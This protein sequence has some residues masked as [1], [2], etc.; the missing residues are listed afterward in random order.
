MSL[1]TI[2]KYERLDVIGHGASG[3][4]YLAKDTLLGR[5]VAL[6]VISA[7]GEE[8]DRV[9]EEARVLDRLS[10]PNILEVHGVDLID[11]KV[12]IDME[13]VRGRDLQHIL[14]QTPQLPIANA[15]SITAQICDG[16]A[17]AHS[18][19]TVHR[20]VKP[21]NI[22]ISQEGVVKLV[23]FGLAEVLGTNSFAVGAGTYSYMAPEDFNE[24]Q[25]SDK[26]SDIWAVGVMLYEMLAGKRPFRASKV[27]DPFSW[28]RAIE[29][30]PIE[31]LRT[32]RPE[33]PESIEK[34]IMKAL[35]R[36]KGARYQTADL[37]ATDIRATGLVS[38]IDSSILIVDKAGETDTLPSDEPS[39]ISNDLPTVSGNGIAH[40]EEAATIA[41]ITFPKTKEKIPD[42]N[43]LPQ[44]T[45]IDS[46]LNLAPDHWEPACDAF[47]GGTLVQWLAA[48]GETPLAAVA[49]EIAN[50][51]SRDKNE[52]LRDF[53]YRAGMETSD[54]AQKR[55]NRGVRYFDSGKF[56]EASIELRSAAR[57]DPMRPHY[58]QYLA[59]SLKAIGDRSAAVA[60]FQDGLSY[61]PNDR[62]LKREY[63]EMVDSSVQISSE[64]VDFGTLRSGETKSVRINIK[65]AGQGAL[66]GRVTS[67]PEWITVEPSTFTTRQRQPLNIV[68]DASKVWKAPGTYK[69]NIV[70]E[71]TGGR[72][73][74]NVSLSVMPSRIGLSKAWFWY[75][76]LFISC[77]AP[78]FASL[79]RGSF[80]AGLIATSLLCGSF[81]IIALTAD[82]KW[83]L[84]WPM[85]VLTPFCIALS[86]ALSNTSMFHNT[87]TEHAIT[88]VVPLIIVMLIVQALALA[89]NP[90]G[91]GRWPVW[92]CITGI[93]GFLSAYALL[94][95]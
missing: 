1:G 85:L 33:I 44:L 5:Q 68:A 58:H 94:T 9:L 79:L 13:Y 49:E 63:S 78:A 31:P 17:Y 7:Q 38:A 57:L 93:A 87:A 11:G 8:R 10:H 89:F 75:I 56:A 23:D 52:K 72:H 59:R 55:Y 19:H 70:L 15:L 48:I 84:R 41:A 25:L 60:A 77:I 95:I 14:L 67:S 42:I 83:T 88:Q 53:L 81:F 24:T 73:E 22:I 71:T 4:V 32:I 27:K 91:F 54:E 61:H 43:G 46:F 80:I 47:A 26:Q 62:G 28:K 69:E 50:D 40:P 2:G 37:I 29:E 82:T 30:D 51:P 18:Q 35:E 16:L 12:V 76:P 3:I 86:V 90:K 66:Q 34:I 74:I 20:D 64:T 36:S 65:H 39:T 92:F 45:D 6:K 21:A